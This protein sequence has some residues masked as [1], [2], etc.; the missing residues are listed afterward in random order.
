MA[1]VTDLQHERT[2]TALKEIQKVRTTRC[3]V[4]QNFADTYMW[5]KHAN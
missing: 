5:G 2:A 3:R 4:M 1:A